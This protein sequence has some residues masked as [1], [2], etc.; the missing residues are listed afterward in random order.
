MPNLTTLNKMRTLIYYTLNQTLSCSAHSDQPFIHFL[1]RDCQNRLACGPW[2]A[3]RGHW[4]E[5]HILATVVDASVRAVTRMS[6]TDVCFSW[7]TVCEIFPLLR[8]V[9]ALSVLQLEFQ[10]ST[11]HDWAE[12]ELNPGLGV[13]GGNGQVAM[14]AK[15]LEVAE[16]EQVAWGSV[17]IKKRK[18][19]QKRRYKNDGVIFFCTLTYTVYT[20]TMFF[21][22][23]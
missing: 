10:I 5:K 19:K 15:I 4:N 21:R 1:S 14:Q 13:K 18:Q 11:L 12:L 9:M 22:A 6:E 17:P 7:L 20:K 2:K 3:C 16:L 8:L 23:W